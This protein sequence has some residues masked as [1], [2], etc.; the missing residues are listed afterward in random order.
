MATNTSPTIVIVTS[1]SPTIVMATNTS[2][3]IV[4]TNT[5][6]TIVMATNTSPSIVDFAHKAGAI[7]IIL[8]SD[9]EDTRSATKNDSGV[10]PDTWWLPDTGIQRGNV[11][12]HKGDQTTPGYPSTCKA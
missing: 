10:Y 12:I 9:P 3:T 8:Y 6:T 4:I 11:V 5:S 2:P 7:G 1:T